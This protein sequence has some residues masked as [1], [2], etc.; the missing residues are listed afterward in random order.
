M[1]FAVRQP[2]PLIMAMAEERL[3]TLGAHKMLKKKK[4]RN[5]PFIRFYRGST[6]LLYYFKD[7]SRDALQER[8]TSISRYQQTSHKSVNVS[9]DGR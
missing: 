8:R 2:L 7:M 4:K 6:D 3:L 5:H 1:G 9:P